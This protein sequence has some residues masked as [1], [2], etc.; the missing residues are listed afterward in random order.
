VFAYRIIGGEEGLNAGSAVDFTKS[1][2]SGR[3]LTTDDEVP[4]IVLANSGQLIWCRSQGR[5]MGW[6]EWENL[7]RK[8]AVHERFRLDEEP[9]R[10]LVEGNRDE[11]EH[12]QYVLEHVL[13]N[14]G[15][16]TAKIDIIAAEW[17]GA[18]MVRYLRRT[19]E[20]KNIGFFSSSD[21]SR[22][23]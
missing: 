13:R 8:S 17:A 15:G 10:N 4:G 11:F 12:V 14:A 21:S 7:P 16:G 2:Q 6:T 20:H 23:D 18:A 9:G 3:G 22:I 19:C 5:A 1:I